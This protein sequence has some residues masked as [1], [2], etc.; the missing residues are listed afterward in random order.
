MAER[1]VG[2][3]SNDRWT[4]EEDKQ[5]LELW[6][7]GKSNVSIAAALRRS[8][9]SVV[10]RI[11]ILKKRSVGDANVMLSDRTKRAWCRADELRLTEM[12]TAGASVAETA[13]AMNRTEAAVQN[14][15]HVLK[16]RAPAT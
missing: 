10:S 12:K 11:Y 16:H 3:N 14:R 5:L 6:T 7:T 9:S 13:A 1:V 2:S 4:D 15:L 8:L